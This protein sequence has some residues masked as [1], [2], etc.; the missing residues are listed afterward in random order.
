[1]TN[2]Q[3]LTDDITALPTGARITYQ[4]D[5]LGW[6]SF[7]GADSGPVG[8]E[9]DEATAEAALEAAGWS[10]GNDHIWTA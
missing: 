4:D 1:M 9:C 6:T 7:D 10:L 5:G 8:E 2:T 3:Q